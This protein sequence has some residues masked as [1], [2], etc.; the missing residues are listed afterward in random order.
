MR[1][2][3]PPYICGIVYRK[4]FPEEQTFIIMEAITKIKKELVKSTYECDKCKKDG[5]IANMVML[6]G[7]GLFHAKCLKSTK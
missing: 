1:L 5:D 7:K 6:I 4:Y 3:F 2:D